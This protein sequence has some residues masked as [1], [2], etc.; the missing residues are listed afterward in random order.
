MN[1]EVFWPVPL[2]E[3]RCDLPKEN[4]AKYNRA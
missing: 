2:N 1:C 3:H 4:I